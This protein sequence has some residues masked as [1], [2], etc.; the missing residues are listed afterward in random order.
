[1]QNRSFLPRILPPLGLALVFAPFAHAARLPNRIASDAPGARARLDHTVSPKVKHAI[2]LSAAPSDRVLDSLTL[3]FNMTAS[4]QAAL[5]QL[6][7]DQQNPTSPRYHQWLTPEQFGAQFGLSSADLAKVSAWLTSQ[8]F[9]VTGVARSGTF[10]SFNGT[11]AQAQR[12]FN[13]SIH[14]LNVD[15]EQH[16]ANMTDVALPPS[17]AG[18]VSTVTGLNNFK[19]K[20]RAIPRTVGADVLNPQ[21]TSSVSGS[22]FIAPNDFYTIYDSKALIDSGT[23]G[24]GVGSG[25]SGGYS[26]AIMCQVDISLDDVAAFRIASGLSANPPTVKLYGTDPGTATSSTSIPST[27]DLSEAQLDVEWAGAAAPAA[28]I[29]YV[30]SKDV[31]NTSLPHA[32]DDDLAPIISIS[33]G[34]CEAAAGINGVDS[35]GQLF[36]QANAEGIT[37][38]GPSGDSGATDCDYHAATAAQGLAVDF[39]G[40][41]P[42]VTSAGGT[43]F[44]EGS[45]TGATSY[46]NNGENSGSA[47]SYIPE[48]VWNESSSSGLGSG[49]G[50]ASIF[51][52]KPAWQLGTGVPNDYARDVPDI[53]LNAAANHDGYLFCSQGSCTNGFRNAAGNL[54][55]VGGT[56]V[57]APSFA[58]ILALVEQKNSFA[59]GIGNANPILYA[60]ANSTNYDSVFHD[61]S[62]GSNSSPC[63]VGTADCPNGGSIGYTAARGYD[64]A[65]GWGTVDVF[66]LANSWISVAPVA[67]TISA[68]SVATSNS[69]CGISGNN[70]SVTATVINGTFDSSGHAVVGATPTGTVQFLIDNAAVGSPVALANGKATSALDTSGLSSGAHTISAAYS[71]D[72]TYAGSRGSLHASDGTLSPIDVISTNSADF[73]ITS[74]NAS[75]S[76]KS[77]G[78]APGVVFTFTPIK[79]FTGPITLSVSSNQA[80]AAGYVFSPASTPVNTVTINSTAGVPVT[81]TLSAFLSSANGAAT[82]STVA[83]NHSSPSQLPWYIGGS[84]ATLAC[85]FLLVLPRRRRWGAILAVIISVGAIGATGCGSGGSSSGA[86]G[87][88]STGT[89]PTSP[90]VTNATPGTYNI[91]ITAVA[92]TSTG[93]LVHRANVVFTVQ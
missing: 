47:L 73:S 38:V 79:G 51:F 31:L 81:L 35:F 30:N 56:S 43:M 29:V 49:G 19:L 5:T 46:W 50:G 77:G 90:S 80:I 60:L 2:D 82:L 63:T 24:T 91:T 61:I 62:T 57:A 54:N 52:S 75:T 71:G 67:R 25:S 83:S 76:V 10:I 59:N 15:G 39:P 88:S 26:I 20:S 44:N 4:Q 14:T 16:F 87:A 53:S 6:L 89:T 32:I 72:V 70:L 48:A 37:I 84:G 18:V 12:A 74:C 93:N 69:I 45:S 36:Q 7:I 17:I 55:V 1:M 64:L 9:T 40:S 34:E 92:A 22:H 58:G 78:T 68:T 3:R 28:R 86:T 85:M 23:N 21:Y 27:G 13:T 65:T 33:Y 41:S 8:G 66:N 11:I 42:F